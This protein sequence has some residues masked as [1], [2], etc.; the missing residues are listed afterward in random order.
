MEMIAVKPWS[1][2]YTL[3]T[4]FQA[5]LWTVAVSKQSTEEEENFKPGTELK[6]SVIVWKTS[7]H[8]FRV[9]A[10]LLLLKMQL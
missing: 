8:D 9:T 5:Q 2:C 3:K 6:L 7:V 10:A 1:K 4:T